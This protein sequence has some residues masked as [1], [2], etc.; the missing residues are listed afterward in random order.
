MCVTINVTEDSA[1]E[2]NEFFLVELN[3]LDPAVSLGQASSSV[4]IVNDDGRPD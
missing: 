3:T 4:A 2:K 1:P